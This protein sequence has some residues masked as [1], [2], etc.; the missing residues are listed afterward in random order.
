MHTRHEKLGD[1][2][3]QILKLA[4]RA[5]ARGEVQRK[6]E[7]LQELTKKA[8]RFVDNVWHIEPSEFKGGDLVRLY[9]NK[10]SGPLA[11][12]KDL[13]IHGGQDNWNDGLSIVARLVSSDREHGDWWYVDGMF[14]HTF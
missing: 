13:W 5:Q 2:L 8:V 10:S 4:Y 9:Y 11:H 12:A 1:S 7:I 14:I 6:R 3:N